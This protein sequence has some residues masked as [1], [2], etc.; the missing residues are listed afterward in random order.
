MIRSKDCE[1]WLEKKNTENES[2][3]ATFTKLTDVCAKI[4]KKFTPAKSS[5][6]NKKKA[7]KK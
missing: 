2:Q 4:I 7:A 3:M 1:D 5:D 6:P